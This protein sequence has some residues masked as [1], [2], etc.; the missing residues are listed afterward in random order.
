MNEVP[1]HLTA[2]QVES[3][4]SAFF[5]K[6][7]CVTISQVR[8][9]TGYA[10][11]T[12]RTADMVAISTWPSRGLYCDG[13][14]IKVS[15]SDMWAELRQPEKADEIAKYCQHWWIAGPQKLL[16]PDMPFPKAWGYIAIDAKLKAKIVKQAGSLKPKPMDLLF[17]CA[18]MRA[19]HKQ[20]VSKAWV[21]ELIRQE[22]NKQ[23][24]K[25]KHQAD[26]DARS[27]LDNAKRFEEATGI[28]LLSEHDS[29]RLS[30]N[31]GRI[32]DCVKDLMEL[33][34]T[35]KEQLLD[36]QKAVEKAARVLAVAVKPFGDGK[37][38]SA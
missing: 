13:I 6:T 36:A 24:A 32:G 12:V 35:P 3:A 20:Y 1:I 25:R 26:S 38:K 15:R 16:T 11:D 23:S 27:V 30:Y 9:G 21:D 28:S 19:F 14:E 5:E 34:K 10:R 31:I 17:V 37:D 8:N 2:K 29:S 18:V 4:A 22:V 7:G 33:Y